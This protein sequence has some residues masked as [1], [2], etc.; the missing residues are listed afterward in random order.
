MGSIMTVSIGNEIEGGVDG[1]PC[2]VG[3]TQFLW[4]N[5]KK[6]PHL[7]GLDID[8]RCLKSNETGTTKFINY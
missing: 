3:R 8:T 5:M 7:A 1:V 2:K 6:R 4:E